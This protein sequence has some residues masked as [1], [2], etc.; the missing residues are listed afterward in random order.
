MSSK[1]PHTIN[2]GMAKFRAFVRGNDKQIPFITGFTAHMIDRMEQLEQKRMRGFWPTQSEIK[3]YILQSDENLK[4]IEKNLT[5]WKTDDWRRD[6]EALKEQEKEFKMFLQKKVLPFARKDHVLHPKVYAY[7]LVSHGV[8]TNPSELIDVAKEDYRKTFIEFKKQ[9]LLVARNLKLNTTS[10][11]NVLNFLKTLRPKNSTDLALYYKDSI[12][13]LSE[14]V[15]KNNI[16]SL[17]QIPPH[18]VREARDSELRASSPFVVRTVPF[19]FKRITPEIVFV[20]GDPQNNSFDSAHKESI[21]NFIARQVM[22]GSVLRYFYHDALKPTSIRATFAEI[23]HNSEGWSHY[24]EDLVY[25]FLND[26]EKLVFLQRKLFRQARMFLDA[27]Y[28]LG[29]VSAAKI[30]DIYLFDL[31]LSKQTIDA[32]F[33]LIKRVPGYLTTS[34][35]GYLLL[36]K[37]KNEF[38]KGKVTEKCFNDYII[39]AGIIPFNDLRDRLNENLLCADV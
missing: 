16:L 20:K 1:D 17:D 12:L 7:Q 27:E 28:H 31:G 36:L 22:P 34:Y 26:E 14:L 10:P 38:V 35:H 21:T 9:A 2:N 18:I 3:D 23:A 32:E 19:S 39:R 13:R 37:L 30:K 25:P 6:F 5:I 24:A 4:E 29:R 33:Q 8:N 15:K 11:G